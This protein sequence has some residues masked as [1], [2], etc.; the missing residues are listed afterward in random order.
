MKSIP[1]AI[2]I[3]MPT[4]NNA[5]YLKSC[6]DSV[7]RQTFRDWEFLIIDDKSP[8]KTEE[9]VRGYSAKDSRIIYIKNKIN[10]GLTENLNYY[11]DQARGKYIARI[12]GDDV[13]TDPGKL[14]NQVKFLE[15]N[16]DCG[17]VGCFAY[18]VDVAGKKLFEI[19]YPYTDKEMRE[20]MLKHCCLLHSAVL[21]RKSVV[22]AVGKYDQQYPYAQDYDLYLKIGKISQFRNIP[23][24]MVNYR[25]NPLGTTQ[26]KYWA[27]TQAMID[28]VKKHK[29]DYPNFL[30]GYLLWN[31][32]K[33]YPVWLRGSLT[34]LI[35]KK[36]PLLLK[37]SGA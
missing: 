32:R 33:Y 28:I 29:K 11:L 27:Q 34:R 36:I 22:Q 14:E 6:I 19:K 25:I 30:S 5:T 26:T 1:P 8:D 18:A 37:L 23:K 17:V 16:P 12:D 9:I 3:I 7:V 31:I 13:W 4:F 35:K 2:S 21:M 24:F 15:N 20:I 10:L